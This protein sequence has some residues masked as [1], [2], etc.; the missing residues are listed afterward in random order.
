MA[1]REGRAAERSRDA[2]AL[3]VGIHAE[4]GEL[5]PAFADVATYNGLNTTEAGYRVRVNLTPGGLGALPNNAVWRVDVT[6]DYER[7]SLAATAVPSP[8]RAGITRA[9]SALR[10][11]AA[12]RG[13]TEEALP[14]RRVQWHGNWTKDAPGEPF[15]GK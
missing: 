4:R 3:P 9:W 10:G 2:R 14:P 6:V 15:A 7:V 5:G 1:A 13:W 12:R 11:S 8:A